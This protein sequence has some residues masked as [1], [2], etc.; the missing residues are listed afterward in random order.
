MRHVFPENHEMFKRQLKNLSN[1]A[2][3][4]EAISRYKAAGFPGTHEKVVINV[5]YFLI[6]KIG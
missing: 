3:K 2:M 6:A 5:I 4:E 1:G